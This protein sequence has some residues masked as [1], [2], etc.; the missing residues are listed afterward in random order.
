MQWMTSRRD[1][2]GTATTRNGGLAGAAGVGL[3]SVLLMLVAF[4]ATP[5]GAQD[6]DEAGDLGQGMEVFN[7]SCSSCHQADGSGSAAGRSLID[8]VIEQPD[9]SVHITSVTDGKGNMPG[10]DG[11]LTV[12]EIDAAVSYLRLTFVSEEA[13]MDELPRTGLSGWLFAVGLGLVGSGGA[14]ILAVEPEL[15]RLPVRAFNR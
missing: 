13:P 10:Y 2:S 5:A 12:D 3:L 8:I 14:V 6:A 11:R 7:A 15:R 9:R 1:G 4:T